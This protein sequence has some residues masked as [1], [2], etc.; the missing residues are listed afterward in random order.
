MFPLCFSAF[1]FF[2]QS[3][4]VVLRSAPKVRVTLAG[5]FWF[6]AFPGANVLIPLFPFLI[7]F[8]VYTDHVTCMPIPYYPITHWGNERKEKEKE[9]P[10][11]KSTVM[12]L[13]IIVRYGYHPTNDYC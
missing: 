1:I 11:A 6:Y 9:N 12:N 4:D 13:D 3:V 8:P 5:L 7:P 2:H 10:Y